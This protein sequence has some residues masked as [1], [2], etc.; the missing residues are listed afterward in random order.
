MPNSNDEIKSSSLPFYPVHNSHN[1]CYLIQ[2]CIKSKSSSCCLHLRQNL[3]SQSCLVIQL[4]DHRFLLLDFSIALRETRVFWKLLRNFSKVVSKST[5]EFASENV[6]TFI[7]HNRIYT[8]YTVYITSSY[9]YIIIPRLTVVL[10][11]GAT[12]TIGFQC[13]FA[14]A[15]GMS[16]GLMGGVH[17]YCQQCR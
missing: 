17:S 12:L 6:V 8:A 11:R 1:Y 14:S 16:Y 2:Y 3:K 10:C 4:Q 9:Q 7:F 5:F 13:V 15:P